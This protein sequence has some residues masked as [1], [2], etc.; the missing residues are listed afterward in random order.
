L[1]RLHNGNPRGKH[2]NPKVVLNFVSNQAS[3]IHGLLLLQAAVQ[4]LH[5]C[6]ADHIKTVFVD[7]K[8]EG[9][10][11]WQGEVEVFELRNHPKAK[12][13]YA[14]FQ[15]EKSDSARPVSVV[16]LL[17]RWPVDSPHAAVRFAIAFDIPVHLLADLIPLGRDVV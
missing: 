1:K 13:C 5:R 4:Q 15:Y 14:W 2:G 16:A 17:N 12:K 6:E 7:D 9:Q 11:M 8:F 3:E 10:A